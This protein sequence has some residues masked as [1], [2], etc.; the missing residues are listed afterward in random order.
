MPRTKGSRWGSD[1]VASKLTGLPTA[2]TAP[3]TSEQIEAYALHVRIEEIT[4]KLRIDDVVTA[5]RDRR[6]PSP[7][8][9][10]DASGRRVNMRHQRHRQ[11]LED[12]RQSLVRVAMRTIPGYRAP[13]GYVPRGGPGGM[14]KEKV[15]IPVKEFPEINFIGQ[16]LG[17]R[18]RSLADMNTQSGANI[19]IRGRGSV[20]E[21]R[22]KDRTRASGR[23]RTDNS[24]D[25]EPLHCLISADTEEKIEKAKSLLK[26]VIE[27][28]V[29]T[30]EHANDRK[31]QQ[32]RDLAVVNGTFRDD[33][34]RIT[35]GGEDWKRGVAAD[36]KC[37]I[38]G[39]GGHISRDCTERKVGGT[40][41]TPPWRRNEQPRM[42]G[43]H[44]EIEY[45][46]LLS[47]IGGV[48]GQKQTSGYY[49]LE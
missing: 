7:E 12:E 49:D 23:F 37:Y 36:I 33:E 46:Q 29:T 1:N 18:G 3:M 42:R 48:T 38:C 14:I 11:R 35:A 10:Y 31:R 43:D 5:D 13:A 15:Y 28:I 22:G 6:S 25:H 8:P 20:K 17:P 41:T 44:L 27:T 24:E 26:S 32:L 4:Q 30:P 47:E 9:Q 39:C 2:I 19:V 21:G 40:R 16:I 34:S 45:Q